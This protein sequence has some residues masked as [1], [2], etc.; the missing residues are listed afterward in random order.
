MYESEADTLLKKISHERIAV[1]INLTSNEFIAGVSGQ[2][3]PITIYIQ[4][5]IPIVISTDDE[6]VSRSTMS[7]EY[8]L[9]ISRY[10]PS[11]SFLKNTVYNSIQFSFL[12]DEEKLN[13]KKI[14][15][16]RF[17]KFEKNIAQTVKDT[18]RLNTRTRK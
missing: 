2:S 7:N 6:G 5:N 12:S 18:R 15:D 8:L 17:A 16:Q 1:E 14:L 9:F 13:H 4:R 3:H 11:Y 10:K